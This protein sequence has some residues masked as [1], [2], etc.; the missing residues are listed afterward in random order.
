MQAIPGLL[1]EIARPRLEAFVEELER[2]RSY[3]GARYRGALIERL[4]LSGGGAA[5]PQLDMYLQ[6]R[7]G[8]EVMI[9]APCYQP[10]IAGDSELSPMFATAVGLAL[11]GG[12][13]HG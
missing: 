7:M 5:L 9:V 12:R 6:Q 11:R 4:Y 2:I 1:W 3:W 8:I 13:T 10:G